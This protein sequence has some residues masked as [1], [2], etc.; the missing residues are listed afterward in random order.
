MFLHKR[1]CGLVYQTWLDLSGNFLIHTMKQYD[2]SCLHFSRR[3]TFGVLSWRLYKKS[4]LE[5]VISSCVSKGYVFQMEMIVR[6]SRKGYRIEEVKL[7][8]WIIMDCY[9]IWQ[10][11]DTELIFPFSTQAL[12]VFMMSLLSF[13][14]QIYIASIH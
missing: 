1:F 4:V 9:C 12:L 14:C 10:L 2:G 6:A 3:N 5:D 13:N 8:F 7:D 11:Y